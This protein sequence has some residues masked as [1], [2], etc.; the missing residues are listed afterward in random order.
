M[1]ARAA[2]V[3]DNPSDALKDIELGLLAS[4]EKPPLWDAYDNCPCMSGKK[5]K[6]CCGRKL[7]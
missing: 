2:L 6:F 5:V 1:L 4:P 7:C 3:S